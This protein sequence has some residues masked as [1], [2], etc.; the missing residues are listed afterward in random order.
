[1]KRLLSVALIAAGFLPLLVLGFVFKSTLGSYIAVFLLGLFGL[2]LAV[3]FVV[4]MLFV[5][6]FRWAQADRTDKT[7]G[8]RKAPA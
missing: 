5:F 6:P 4:F 3:T 8:H 7:H 2:S 1:M